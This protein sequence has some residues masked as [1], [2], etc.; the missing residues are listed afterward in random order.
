[1]THATEVTAAPGGHTLEVRRE[2]AAPPA[3]VFRAHT[4]PDLLAQWLGP[5]RLTTRVE[6]LEVRDGGRWRFVHV[7]T[8]GAE[9]AFR[10]VFHGTPTP[11][12]IVQTWEF[13]SEPGNVLLETLTLTPT[14]GGGTLLHGVSLFRDAG[15]RDAALGTG[16]VDGM[17]ESYARLAELLDRAGAQVS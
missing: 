9:Y 17:E 6:R 8:D 13:E 12:R 7:D 1:M 14:A 5:R 2:F 16:M 11:E 4:E 3:L 10:G 15:T